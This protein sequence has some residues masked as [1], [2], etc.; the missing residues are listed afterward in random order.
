MK[1]VNLIPKEERRGEAAAN[2]TG[3]LAYAVVGVL[4]LIVVV[5]AATTLLGNQ[6][7]DRK[8]Q[9]ASLETQVQQSE[10]RAS[11]LAPYVQLAQVREARTT[12]IDSL[13]KSRFDWER[14]LRELALVTPEGIALSGVTGTASADVEVDGAADVGLRTQV[15][16]PAL[17]IIGC[18]T[19]QRQLAEYISALQDIDGVSRVAAQSS[20]R[21]TRRSDSQAATGATECA[22]P[23]DAAFELVAALEG[24]PTPVEP[25]VGDASAVTAT[26]TTTAAPATAGTASS[27]GGVAEAQQQQ[28]QQ[29]QEISNAATKSDDATNLVPG[30]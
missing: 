22:R 10:A 28:S 11:A 20:A 24:V 19:D 4:A 16:G 29:Q 7:S 1:P 3:A 9:V 13:A 2:R 5:L 25:A 12:T 17:E 30:G 14:V 15:P 23:T 6:I 8:S 26:A 18:A 21:G 27:D